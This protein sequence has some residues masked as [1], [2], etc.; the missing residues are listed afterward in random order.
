M[1]LINKKK[2][3]DKLIEN[4]NSIF[5]M[6]HKYLDLD[7]IGSAIGV[8]EYVKQFNKNCT[9]I[10][11]DRKLEAGVKKV[12]D[13]VGNSYRI[14]KSSNI[15]L[16]INSKSLLIIVDT[17]KA[18]LLQDPNL[19]D[20]FENIIVIDH[21]DWQESSIDRGVVIIDEDSSSTCEMLSI[22][23]NH[24]KIDINEDV[25]TILLSGIVLDTNNFV[26]KT[27]T[28]TFKASYL[29]AQKGADP[30]YVQYLLKQDIKK[31][32]E[33]QK[34]VTNVKTMGCIA[35]SCAKSN[36]IYR[37][38]DLAKIA[39][40]LMLFNKIE[41]SFVIG[42]L[43]KNTVGISARSVGTID[44]GYILEQFNGGGDNHE[45]GARIDNKSIKK[46][47]DELLRIIKSLA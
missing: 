13:K 46:I 25:A 32:I 2:D 37:R 38:E 16:K 42:K 31:Y 3:I 27:T 22:F 9:I 10:I 36:I 44:V 20:S 11:N 34:V 8:Y 24:N 4:S 43:D 18:Q 30:N 39:D 47:E 26:L 35:I 33:R 40:T 19:I 41:A 23:L 14:N 21:H 5:I 29:L 7:A 17:N 1:E 28:N 45:A 12:L 15:K 6:G